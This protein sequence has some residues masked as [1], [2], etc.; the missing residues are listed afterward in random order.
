MFKQDPGEH[1]VHRKHFISI[2]SHYLLC[3]LHCAGDGGGGGKAV[4]QKKRNPS[5]SLNKSVISHSWVSGVRNVLVLCDDDCAL[6]CQ[7]EH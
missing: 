1:K 2:V 7:H 3:I 6:C 5:D 4:G